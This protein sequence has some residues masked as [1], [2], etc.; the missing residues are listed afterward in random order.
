MKKILTGLA[1]A[2]GLTVGFVTPSMAATMSNG[3]GERCDGQG[4]WHFINNQVPS[5]SPTGTLSA[6][7]NL[8]GVPTVYTT[9]A[10]D[11]NKSTQHFY[12]S[13][14][15]DATLTAASTDLGGRLVLSHFDCHGDGDPKDPKK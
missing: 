14:S 13:T 15:G 1:L 4:L 9:S 10:S 3:V 12:V 11:V 8:D 5:G 6:T 7:F 2:A